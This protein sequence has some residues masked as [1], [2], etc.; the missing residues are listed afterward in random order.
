MVHNFMISKKTKAGIAVVAIVVAGALGAGVWNAYGSKH[1]NSDKQ[2]A[3]DKETV[4]DCQ[5]SEVGNSEDYVTNE[6]GESEDFERVGYKNPDKPEEYYWN[7]K[8]LSLT[9][10]EYEK[11]IEVIDKDDLIFFADKTEVENAINNSGK[12]KEDNEK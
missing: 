1:D 12:N 5:T 2:S 8:G 9:K 11:A 10:E 3:K 6:S 4:E 7:K